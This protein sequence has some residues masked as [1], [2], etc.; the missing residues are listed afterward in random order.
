M[1]VY[2]DTSFLISLYSPDANSTA[3]AQIIQAPKNIHLLSTFTESEMVN[4]LQL[5]VF[6]KEISPAQA[7]SSLRDFEQDLRQGVF[8]LVRLPEEAFQRAHQISRQ[9]TARLGTRTADLLHVAAALEL[10]ADCLYSFDRQQR[11]LA[12]V[13]KLKLN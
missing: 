7:K 11:K 5:R 10:N 1:R 9:T 2:L 8:Q 13:F 4:A 6:R 3:A 12:Q